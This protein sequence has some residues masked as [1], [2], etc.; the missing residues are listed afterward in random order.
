[1]KLY[2]LENAISTATIIAGIP[3]LLSIN[4]SVSAAVIPFIVCPDGND[5]SYGI[6]TIRSIVSSIWHGRSLPNMFFSIR[7]PTINVSSIAISICMPP[8]LYFLKKSNSTAITIHSIPASPSVESSAMTL[9]KNGVLISCNAY[10]KSN[11][12]PILFLLSYFLL[13]FKSIITII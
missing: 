13:K 7:F 12:H 5:E 4:H 3:I 1:M 9:S 6:F 2:I 11:S 8:R 10:R